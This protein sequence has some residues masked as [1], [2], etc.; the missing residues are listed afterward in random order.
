MSVRK[1]KRTDF[2]PT[3]EE[4]IYRNNRYNLLFGETKQ[5]FRATCSVAGRIAG[6]TG[7]VDIKHA[8]I[9]FADIQ[10]HF[11]AAEKGAAKTFFK[12]MERTIIAKDA[13]LSAEPYDGSDV[14]E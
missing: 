2:S 1:T 12:A 7:I 11:S 8:Q 14:F 6:T 9:T 4:V 13:E 10:E 5:D 3:D